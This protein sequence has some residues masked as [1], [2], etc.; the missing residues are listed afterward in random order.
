MGVKKLSSVAVFVAAVLGSVCHPQRGLAQDEEAQS[1]ASPAPLAG[2]ALPGLGRVG[3]PRTSPFLLGASARVGYGYTESV[4]GLDDS[5]HRIAGR[6]AIS[7]QPLDFLQVALRLDGRYDTHSGTGI[8][9]DDGLVGDPRL[10]VRAFHEFGDFSLGAEVTVWFPGNDAPSFAFDATT[11]DFQALAAYRAGNLDLGLNVGY[12]LD[13]SA[14]SAQ[15]AALLSDS[16]RLS[17]GVSDSDALLLGAGA[18]YRFGAQQIFAEWTWDV[19]MGDL[20]PSI[21]GSPMRVGGGFRF[22]PNDDNSMQIEVGVEAL[23]SS[24]PPAD[25]ASPLTPFDPRIAGHVAFVYRFPGLESGQTIEADDEDPIVG[26]VPDAETG[27][28]SGRALDDQ[29]N[30][31]AGAE[32]VLTS[33]DGEVARTAT[34]DSDGAYRFGDVPVGENYSITVRGE[35]YVEYSGTLAVQEGDSPAPAIEITRDLPSGQIRGVVQSFRGQPIQ[36]TVHID[37]FGGEVTADEEGIFEIDV[38]PGAYTVTVSAEG[39]VEQSRPIIVEEQGVT[40]LNVDLRSERV[41][42]G[43]RSR[44]RR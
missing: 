43:R 32:V 14:N 24:R 26:T 7:V 13:Q 38:P 17:L 35:G 19:L 39:Y 25:A 1:Q 36:A 31:I 44:R 42:R 28:V 34:T 15:G 37:P 6:L 18:A 3:L 33:P 29:G 2:D 27:T 16:D 30:P 12:R 10:L 23:L 8:D 21:S 11:V 40:I 41:R 22:F 9:G 20:A 5:H 4:L